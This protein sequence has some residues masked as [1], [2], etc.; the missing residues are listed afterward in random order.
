MA[1]NFGFSGYPGLLFSMEM[2]E[3]QLMQRWLCDVGSVDGKYLFQ[4]RLKQR[5]A[6]V[7]EKLNRAGQDIA[8]LPVFWDDTANLTISKIQARAKKARMLHGIRWI[9]VDYLR[10][11]PAGAFPARR[12]K[13]R[14]PGSSSSWPRSWSWW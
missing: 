5:D 4:G 1:R 11:F 14:S 8:G 3:N 2:P 6:G 7:W 12:P 10:R 9:A 13:P